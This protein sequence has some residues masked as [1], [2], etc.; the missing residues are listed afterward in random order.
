MGRFGTLV[1][2]YR[3]GVATSAWVG[4]VDV[5]LKVFAEVVEVSRLEKTVILKYVFG[6][7]I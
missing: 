7:E 6:S 2:I 4:I 1:A 3:G 5:A